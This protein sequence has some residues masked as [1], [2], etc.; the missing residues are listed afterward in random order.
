M[1]GKWIIKKANWE[2][3]MEERDRLS[4]ELSTEMLES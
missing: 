1:G 3:F 4:K 2:T